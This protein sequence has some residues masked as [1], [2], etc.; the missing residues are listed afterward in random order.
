M[1]HSIFICLAKP[2]QLACWKCI[3]I[4]LMRISTDFIKNKVHCLCA[5]QHI[6]LS[7]F[8]LNEQNTSYE[9]ENSED[10]RIII[11]KYL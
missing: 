8:V 11:Y 9:D 4:V 2:R 5:S 1:K 10:L 3:K 6:K 7:P